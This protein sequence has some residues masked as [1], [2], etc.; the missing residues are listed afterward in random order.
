MNFLQKSILLAGR[1]ITKFWRGGIYK[2]SV[3]PEILQYYEE[4]EF[5]NHQHKQKYC[6]NAPNVE[7]KREI[8]QNDQ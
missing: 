7:F 2:P 8:F 3:Q 5:I 4:V 1:S 6:K